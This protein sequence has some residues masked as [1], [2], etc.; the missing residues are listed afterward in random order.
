MTRPNQ[1]I[2]P[3]QPALA[4]ETWVARLAQA[5]ADWSG[6]TPAFALATAVILVWLLCGPLFNYSDTWQ[7]AVNTGTTIVTFLM[8]FLIQRAQNK[9]AQAVHLK[10]NELIAA[11]D[12]ASNRLVNAENLPEDELRRLHGQFSRLLNLMD[13]DRRRS[14][15]HTV[16]EA[17]PVD[18]G[19]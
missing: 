4:R 16:D 5:A 19:F 15:P 11:V 3:P 17:A 6:T 8:V 2:P 14:E 12:G 9:D 13:R 7:L 10:L 1:S 18:E